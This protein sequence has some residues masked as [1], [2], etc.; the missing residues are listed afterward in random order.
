MFYEAFQQSRATRLANT[1]G[2]S[3]PLTPKICR[4]MSKLFNEQAS[5]TLPPAQVC[6]GK[7]RKAPR[8]CPAPLCGRHVIG[9][10]YSWR[11]LEVVI[12]AGN[13][14][15]RQLH[16]LHGSPETPVTSPPVRHGGAPPRKK[17]P[18]LPCITFRFRPPGGRGSR[19]R[20]GAAS[21]TQAS[22]SSVSAQ[23][24]IPRDS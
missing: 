17:D 3:M 15:K 22:L 21:H 23:R 18:P 6:P 5:W 20:A 16:L 10:I 1:T 24:V 4:L 7:P 8:C 9:L 12:V 2:P 19:L 14:N 11:S 13:Q